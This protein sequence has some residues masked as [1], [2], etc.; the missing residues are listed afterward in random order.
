MIRRVAYVCADPGVP[1]FGAKGCSIHVQ[2]VIRGMCRRGIAVDLFATRFDGPIP[3][4]FDHV[5]V[6][7]LPPAPKGDLA[8]RERLCL[9]GNDDLRV[10]LEA[11]GESIDL[12][13]QRY[14]LWSDAA[15]EWAHARRVP[16]VLEV[17]A[18]LIDEQAVHRGLVDRDGAEA[19]ARRVFQQ[20]SA[21]TCVSTEVANWLTERFPFARPRVHVVPN[22]VDADRFSPQVK[23]AI[24]AE[25]GTMTIGFV[26]TLKQWHGLDYL[27]DVFDRLHR[28][29]ASWRL[30]LIGD[31]PLRETLEI[32]ARSRGLIDSITFTGMI[33]SEQM[34]AMLASID[35]A[36][37]PYPQ[38][39]RFYFSPMK[40]FEYMAA[41][42]PIVGSA[43]GQ[44]EQVIEDGVSGILARPGDIDMWVEGL[45]TL[46]H[47][48][49][50]RWSLGQLARSAAIAK[51]SWDSVVCQILSLATD[52]RDASIAT[53]VSA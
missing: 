50:L 3:R 34:P 21:I 51:H 18:P 11:T 14:S 39:D 49:S 20:A 24:F 46:R 23:P 47:S 31:G 41:G 29:D 12:V 35:I 53:E 19:V 8:L 30:M 44:V 1:V 6:H 15:I 2:E 22:G 45:T 38:L 37:A 32:G 9:A 25:P 33:P 40:L 16:S 36:V 10:A 43:I 13:Y 26:G 48:P 28:R 5:R 52:S 27:I 7:Q 42:L 17:N 4:G